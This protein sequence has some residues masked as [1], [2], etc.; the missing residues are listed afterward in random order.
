MYL[1]IKIITFISVILKK[2][3]QVF[4]KTFSLINDVGFDSKSF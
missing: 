1:I 4:R 3:S 2:I